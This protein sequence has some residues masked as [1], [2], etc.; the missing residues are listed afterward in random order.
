MTI[1]DVVLNSATRAQLESYMARPTHAL[2]LSGLPG[3]GLGTIANSL[4][5][6]IAGPEI[7]TIQ[8]TVHSKNKSAAPTI[9]IEDIR[10]INSFIGRRRTNKLVIVLDDIDAMTNDAPEAFLKLLEEP[11]R[12]VYYLL[13]THDLNRVKDTILSRAQVITVLPASQ[14]DCQVL[15]E[16]SPLRLTDDKRKKISFMAN[17]YPAE[18]IRLVT[19]EAHFRSKAES[20]EKAK[21]FLTGST[22]DRLEIISGI[23]NREL[24]AELARNLAK[25]TILTA[26]QA[27][28]VKQLP[29][30]LETISGVLDN[31]KQNGNTRAQLLFLALNI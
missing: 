7:I 13:T 28:H 2:L 23:G 30:K 14:D 3:V 17:G 8:P 31:L 26:G 10:S 19:D 12:E 11:S 24:A 9:N 21:L 4:A 25:L 22:M 16:Q 20:I 29:V 1:D 15:F 6:Q 18:I 5:K 27:H